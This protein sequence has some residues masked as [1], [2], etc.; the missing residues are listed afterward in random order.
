MAT[1]GEAPW[2]G[3]DWLASVTEWAGD[4]LRELGRAPAGEP[5]VVKRWAIS[6]LVRL[7]TDGGDFFYKAVPGL[8]AREPR[9][10]R[11]LAAWH[12]GAVPE[13]VAERNEGTDGAVGFL[14]RGFAG[15]ELRQAGL[16]AEKSEDE[17]R[18]MA[19]VS[20][21]AR[22]HV[23]YAG[24][25]AAELPELGCPV[26]PLA[27]LPSRFAAVL[28]EELPAVRL[29]GHA[30]GEGEADAAAAL[31]PRIEAACAALEAGPLPL[32]TL[33]HGD[34]HAGN[35]VAVP[36]GAGGTVPL[37]YDWTDAAAAHPLMDLLVFFE[38]HALSGRDD[39]QARL[40]DA[41]LAPWAAAG[42]GQ[43]D[44]LRAAFDL[45]QAVA[46]AYHLVS[47]GDIYAGTGEAG[48]RDLGFAL[49]WLIRL[50][51]RGADRLPPA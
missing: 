33:V 17:A 25:A 41:Y 47:Y 22:L 15:D 38:E 6:C 13:V 20:V 35:V 30:P 18:W 43:L 37:I 34:F 11:A 24:R 42:F 31:L 10:L 28:S 3:E 29:H 51:L 36:D 2:Y 44:E 46:P 50:L 27:E 23:E 39:L 7:P 16:V 40:R 8:F 1:N 48:R 14:M 32:L 9:V 12:P 5:E 4:R 19:A 21:L 49:P 26:R 45:G